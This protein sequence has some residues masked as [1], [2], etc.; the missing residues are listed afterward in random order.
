MV[1]TTNDAQLCH[2]HLTR[3]LESVTKQIRQCQLE[4]E[5]QSLLCPIT[6]VALDR[7]DY[8]L[9]EFVRGE[10][11]YLSTRN[12]DQLA[13]FRETIHGKELHQAI[14]NCRLP[15]NLV[16]RQLQD[17]RIILLSVLFFSTHTSIN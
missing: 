6:S 1:K 7:I 15:S 2:A 9:K 12:N 11:N 5:K 17:D 16:S 4:L 10:R 14:V 3:H 8:G 13:K